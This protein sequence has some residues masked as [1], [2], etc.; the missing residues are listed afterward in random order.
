MVKAAKREHLDAVSPDKQAS[1][2][3]AIS[4]KNPLALSTFEERGASIAAKVTRIRDNEAFKKLPK[5]KQVATLGNLYDE[6]VVPSYKGFNLPVPAKDTWVKLAEVDHG[7][8]RRTDANSFY[9]TP[10]EQQGMHVLAGLDTTASGIILFGAKV[11]NKYFQALHSIDNVFSAHLPESMQHHQ[12]LTDVIEGNPAHATPD[13]LE[14]YFKKAE[15]QNQRLINYE[16]QHIDGVDVWLNSHYRDS[17]LNSLSRMGGEALAAMPIYEAVGAGLGAAGEIGGAGSLSS[18]L[19]AT[20]LGKWV[21]GTLKTATDGYLSTLAVTGDKKEANVGAI[22]GAILHGA[23]APISEKIASFPLIKKWTASILAMGGKPFAQ[24]LAA[25]AMHEEE[26]AGHVT[27]PEAIKHVEGFNKNRELNDPITAQ[28]HKAEKVSQDSIAQQMYGK[29]V[30][31]LSKQQRAKVFAKRLELINQAAEE[32]PVHLPEM[33]LAETK[34]EIS[35]QAEAT[36]ELGQW[37]KTLEQNFGGSVPDVV[38][39]NTIKAVATETGIVDS[40]VVLKKLS[41]SQQLMKRAKEAT[42]EYE[43]IDGAHAFHSFRAN[44]VS[45]LRNPTRGERLAADG[46][47]V[48]SRDKRTWNEILKSDNREKFIEVLKEADGNRIHFENDLHR[49]L[50]HYSNRENLEAPLREKLLREIKK[51]PKGTLKTA[52]DAATAADNVAV[53]LY[54]LAKSGRLSEEG[55]MFKSTN[56]NPDWNPT[57]WQMQLHTENDQEQLQ[58][59]KDALKRHPKQLKAAISGMNSL[60]SMKYQAEDITK[61]LEIDAEIRKMALSHAIGGK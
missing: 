26:V 53:H 49:M 47:R 14:N 50:Y 16:K 10:L 37:F 3:K 4:T 57:K 33:Q 19:G 29:G 30:R 39:K 52:Q 1:F 5:E 48:G 31:N 60:I 34:A 44:T 6:Y 13:A 38:A 35:K 41:K 23:G 32:A 58:M 18:K 54:E 2:L 25:S 36:P 27:T 40:S 61:Y 17:T 21:Y 15:Q 22:G 42:A 9:D 28:L 12:S 55:N 24:D 43:P 46:T 20:K 45:F 51:Y 56:I 8:G 7:I 59:V 11:S